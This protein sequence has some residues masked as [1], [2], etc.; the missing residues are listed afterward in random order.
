MN[1]IAI[2]S[3]KGGTGKTTTT[4]NLGASL[5]LKGYQVLLVDNDP[6]GSLTKS[7]GFTPDKISYT[8][9]NLMLKAIEEPEELPQVIDKAIYHYDRNDEDHS[10][11]KQVKL[12]LIPSNKRLSNIVSRLVSMQVTRNLLDTDET[13][14]EFVIKTALEVIKPRYDYI[15]IDCSP[16]MDLQMVNAL[17]A[18]NEV[19]IP[20]Q[21]HYL[22]SEGMPDTI[23]II[24]KVKKN[25]N[26]DL[27]IRGILLTMF[28]SRTKL[29]RTVRENLESLYGGEIKIFQNPIDYSVRV[30]EH[31]AFGETIFTYEPNTPAALAYKAVADEVAQHG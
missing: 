22:D 27:T 23:D 26:P 11:G 30:A 2:L 1:T 17:V 6:Q 12:D 24:Q 3:V 21:A 10:N 15:L 31:P 20:V 8:L 5:A 29:A 7:L 16:K 19:I 9:C 14:S 25:Y 28:Q 13:R 4:V 18:A